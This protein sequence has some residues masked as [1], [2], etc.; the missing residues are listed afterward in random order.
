MMTQRKFFQAPAEAVG[1]RQIR[2]R[3]SSPDIDR[4]GDIVVQTGIKFADTVPVLWQHDPNQPIGRAK[5]VMKDGSLYADIEFAPAGIS[6]KADEI[7]GLAKAGVVDTVSI[8]FD[9]IAAEPMD[10]KRP[11]G[12]KKY[13]SIEL[14]ELSVVSVPANADAVV[15][16]R[17]KTTNE[18]TAEGDSMSDKQKDAVRTERVS[19]MHE[20][21]KT[22]GM[23]QIG[24]FANLLDSL[25]WLRDDAKWEA[26]MEGDGSEVPGLIADALRA[27][28]EAFLALTAEE[29]AEL[30]GD[31]DE[32]DVVEVLDVLP[33]GEAEVVM[34]GKTIA[35]RKFRAAFAQAKTRMVVVK[36]G[37]KLSAAT[38]KC[39]EE[40]IGTHKDA[41]ASHK[42]AMKAVQGLLDDSG[43]AEDETTAAA[44]ETGGEGDGE[45]GKSTAVVTTKEQ[46]LAR[47]KQ[48]EPA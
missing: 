47:L 29:V 7:C 39:L 26:A 46:R 48:F 14:L 6:T 34:S 23:W 12:P 28:A 43:T 17:N 2:V 16:Q 30:L 33:E 41:I 19:K 4:S 3:C 5:P 22:K 13:L 35:I 44:V 15:V 36:S 21:L 42:K 37:K 40:S 45:T 8:G 11:K 20:A 9:T 38:R 10:S 27:A 24:Y 1:E 18:D 31:D 32:D 25:G